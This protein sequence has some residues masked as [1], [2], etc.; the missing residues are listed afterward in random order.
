METRAVA[1]PEVRAKPKLGL[2]AILLTLAVDCQAAQAMLLTGQVEERA[3]ALTPNLNLNPNQGQNQNLAPLQSQ[4]ARP[5]SNRTD[6]NGPNLN[7]PSQVAQPPGA[8]KSTTNSFP[9][10]YQ[11]A[12]YCQTT[13]VDSTLPA[14]VQGQVIGSEVVFFLSKD[15]GI[16]ARW[17]QPGWVETQSQAITFNGTEAKADRTT[18]Y[19]GDNMQGS[20]AARARDQF[21]QTGPDMIS[22]KSYVDQYL[23]GQ[24]L[25]RYRTVSVLKRSG[26][27]QSMA[28]MN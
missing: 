6:L 9:A 10:T 12:W 18:Y 15:G 20:W 7:R 23:D 11:G 1:K 21:A 8:T 28:S 27:S 4:Q 16:H 24:Y 13:V 22:A 19:F 3:E 5:E 26:T 25:G 17:N 2:I 14:V